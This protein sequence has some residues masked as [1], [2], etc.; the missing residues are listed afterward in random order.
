MKTLHE[1]IVIKIIL[2]AIRNFTGS[3]CKLKSRGVI[4]HIYSNS[5]LVWQQHSEFFEACSR[6]SKECHTK[7][8]YNSQS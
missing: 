3:Q 2:K 6:D 7:Y 4:W 1:I 5:K 8:Y